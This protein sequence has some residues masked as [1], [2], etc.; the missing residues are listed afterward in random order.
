LRR[1]IIS[2]HLN[3]TPT[4][5][6]L[7]CCVAD[8]PFQVHNFVSLTLNLFNGCL[9]QLFRDATVPTLSTVILVGVFAHQLQVGQE[10]RAFL[11]GVLLGLVENVFQ[12][13]WILD[14]H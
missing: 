2:Y 1:L 7:Q 9:K 3:F 8:E 12:A 4:L 6:V 11:V 10:L 13:D 14:D 5:S